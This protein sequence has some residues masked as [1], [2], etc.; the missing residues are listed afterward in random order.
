MKCD[1][2]G[3][4][5]QINSQKKLETMQAHQHTVTSE[6][7]QKSVSFGNFELFK[8]LLQPHFL[9]NSLNNLYALSVKSSDQTSDA[10]A[11]LSD[12]L[13]RV[14]SCSQK[15]YVTVEEEMD[16]IHQYIALE[17]IWLGEKGFLLDMEVRGD[18]GMFDIPPLVLYTFIEN[19][20]KHGIRKCNT[21]GWLSVKVEV[22][23]ETL[24]F[25]AKNRVPE[26]EYG[27]GEQNDRVSGLGIPAAMELL[28]KKCKGRYFLKS[29]RKG[30]IYSV[31]L[32]I[33]CS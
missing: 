11:G 5:Q 23:N 31:D 3:L 16:L 12:L 33:K 13:V 6:R 10:I 4:D 7:E 30:N 20:F 8:M 24:L 19:C 2:S 14:V 32:Q 28:N 17:K 21:D 26:M 15:D 25:R 22:R 29:G 9:F 18:V 27:F 1:F